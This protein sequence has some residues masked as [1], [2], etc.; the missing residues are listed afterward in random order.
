MITWLAGWL[1]SRTASLPDV[2]RLG[3]QSGEQD[4]RLSWMSSIQCSANSF[5]CSFSI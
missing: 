4:G 1:A 5:S 2:G 3:E